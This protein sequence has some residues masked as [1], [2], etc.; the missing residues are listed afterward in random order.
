MSEFNQPKQQVEN[1]FNAENIHF[2]SSNFI[3]QIWDKLEPDLQDAIALAYNQAQREGGDTVRTK[4]LFAALARLRPEPITEFLD[5]FPAEAFPK[6]LSNDVST[7]RT[8]LSENPTL[9]GCV[10]TSLRN[11]SARVPE[12]RKLSSADVLVDIAE[13][14]TGHTV[15][16]L[17]ENGITKERINEVVGELG[18]NVIRR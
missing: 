8:L 16:R 13:N 12:N 14:G 17:R 5:Y 7:E 1:Q 2:N 9:S 3:I 15:A 11:L 10:D 4:N 18:W 6:P